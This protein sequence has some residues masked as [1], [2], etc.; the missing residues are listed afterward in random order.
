MAMGPTNTS[1]LDKK[2]KTK[3]LWS[4]TIKSKPKQNRLMHHMEMLWQ[5]KHPTATVDVKQLDNQ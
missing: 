2:K 5:E 4:V 3:K 1:Q